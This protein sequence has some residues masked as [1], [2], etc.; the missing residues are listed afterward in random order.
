MNT[1]SGQQDVKMYYRGSIP[2]TESKRSPKIQTAFSAGDS[3]EK[4]DQGSNKSSSGFSSF[5][6]VNPKE[7]NTSFQSQSTKTGNGY[8]IQC[9]IALN[10]P[11]GQS[12]SED[13]AKDHMALLGSVLLSYEGLVAG[14]IGNP[15]LT[16]EDYDQIDAEE[17]EL[18]DIKWC[19]A[20]VLRRAEKFKT[21]TG[22][23]DFLDAHV[24]TLGFDKSKVTCFR[25]REK[26][27][28][29]RE[30]KGREASGA[31]NPFGKD[32]YYRKAIY[33]QVGQSQEPQTA[34]GRKIEDP[35]R[36]CLVD[37]SWSD[38]ISSEATEA[39]IIDQ[40]DEKLPEGFSWDMFVDKKG[41]FKAFIAKIVREP[42]LFATWMRSIGENVK[43]EDEKSVSSD[44][45]SDSTDTLS[46][47]SGDV[48]DSSDDSIQ[49]LDELEQNENVPE[50]KVVF[51]KTPS[52]SD[53][54]DGDSDKSVHFD[55]SPD[56]SSSDDEKEKH[57]NIA[58]SHLPP[59]NFHFY[60]A[61]RMKKLKEKQAAKEQQSEFEG[62][63]QNVESVDEKVIKVEKEVEKVIELEKVIEVVKT[64]EVEKI[65]EVVKPCEKCLEACKECAAKGDIIAEYEKKKEQ[66]LFNLNYVK[67]SYD[68]LNKTVTG[69]QTTNSEREQALTMMNATLMSKQKAINFYIEE[70]AKWKQELETEKIENERIR[71]LLLSYSTSDYLID[72]VYPTVAGMEAFQDEKP[73][74]KKDCGKKT[75]V[76]YNK[77]PPPI[78][79][80]YSPRKPNE[81]QL[82]KAVNIKL[83]TDTTDV[84]PENI[85]VTF[86]SS[87]T[88]HESELIKKVVDQVLDTDEETES[89]SESEKPKS[90]V[91]SQNS[92]VKRSYSKEFLLSKADLND[93]TFEVVY[94]LN[95]SDNLYY[96]K[97]FPIMSIKTELINKT[98]KLIEVNIPELNV[99]KSFDKPKKYTSRVQQRLN[100]KKSY[101][102]G[103]GFSKKLNQNCSYKKKGLGFV[104]PENH[105][106]DKN[107]KSNTEFVSGGSSEDEQQKPFWRQSN[108]EFLTERRRN[109]TGVFHLRNTQTC[110]KCNEASHIASNCSK[111]IKAKQ[112]VS[113]KLKEKVV[114]KSE[115]LEDSK[116]EIG[117]CSKKHFYKR[118]G[119]N[120]Q[121]WVAKKVEEKR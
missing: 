63:V 15:M 50:K 12:F 27:H 60:F 111:D 31:Q 110:F 44:E 118:K 92:S 53:I 25:C 41:E 42:N 85:N 22:R 75:T 89:K 103:S 86:T 93:E 45:S 28:F 17:M 76:S 49:S 3:S 72:R 66:L 62:D 105:K 120:N 59:E 84:L 94:T 9:N 35:K 48:S 68:V 47:H 52:D 82:A 108:K 24:S 39:R 106:N 83:K 38:Y 36:A 64:V 112:G 6:S 20:S 78:W 98:F 18:M 56:N 104:P 34:H 121:V 67:E 81:E 4:A 2:A 101:N 32:D 16:K 10:L 65:V 58:K 74:E 1:P 43:S 71:R 95:G 107:S 14:R 8:V 23:N 80:G 26:G 102:S 57:I 116:Y 117:E 79:D 33:Q 73:K 19:L 21:I 113:Q 70:S 77:C 97:E 61:E 46:E 109:G 69:L 30:C 54:S 87:D 91:N 114:E 55:K 40:D 90:S 51:D 100:K 88:D 13:T 99:L 29:K 11:E 7:T 5:P 119:N 96:N 37:F 115:I